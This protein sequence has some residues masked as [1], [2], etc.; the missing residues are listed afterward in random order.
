M[1]KDCV[2]RADHKIN[3]R[4][5]I[6][7]LPYCVLS[8]LG[9]NFPAIAQ[10]R[11][12][13]D[14]PIPAITPVDPNDQYQPPPVPSE[15]PSPILIQ[16]PISPSPTP[17]SRNDRTPTAA[18]RPVLHF[19][20]DRIDIVGA[21][22]LEVEIA[23][24]VTP[25]EQQTLTLDQL[26]KL[27]TEITQLY[28]ENGYTTSGAFLPNNQDLSDGMI[29]IQVVEGELEDL[30]IQGLNRLK[31]GYVR[32]RIARGTATPLNQK[33]LEDALQLLQLNPLIRRVD[34]ELTAGSTPGRSLLRVDIERSP[35]LHIG[36]AF[37]N[38]RNPA[39][40][41]LQGSIDVAHDNVLGYGDRLAG[42]YH[43]TDGLNLFDIGYTFPINAKDGTIGVQ[44][45]NGESHIIEEAFQR[46]EIRS[47]YQTL[48]FNLRQP[49]IKKPNREI[50]LG[51]TFDL[52]QSKSF[53][54]DIPFSF[55]LGPD[56]GLSKVRTLRLSQEWVQRQPSNVFALRSQFNL[57]LDI[58]DA[59]TNDIGPSA[60]FFSW[61]GQAQWVQQLP[62]RSLFIARLN[63]QLTPDSLLSLEKIGIGGIHSV[64]GYTQTQNLTDNGIFGSIEWRVPLTQNPNTLQIS[65]FLDAG[66]GWNNFEANPTSPTL[67]G[68]GL[69]LRWQP[70]SDLNLRLDY[71]IPLITLNEPN[72]SLQESGLYFSIRYQPL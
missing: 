42:S 39:I 72:E 1:N 40:G 4:S 52:R 23:A 43:V 68:L 63:T 70:I 33:S 24:L 53:L 5:I 69:G 21:T 41:S 18:E 65:P 57:G 8:I 7:T 66:T 58:F 38:A 11:D 37:D 31:K 34:A 61:L 10:I 26:L 15:F 28:V 2:F 62:W 14:S 16:P 64:R 9:L 46:E 12:L 48:S 45:N 22:V 50:A 49:I 20:V 3:L 35:D 56:Q 59:T 60:T 25:L 71:G 36:V 30:Q 32:D 6:Q 51:L 19:F 17:D 55:N 27:R 54:G 67:V 29:Q 44:Y 13:P 47:H